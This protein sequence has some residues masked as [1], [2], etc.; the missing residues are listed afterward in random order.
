MIKAVTRPATP[1]V[2]IALRK[3]FLNRQTSASVSCLMPDAPFSP[4]ARYRLKRAQ[5]TKN[6]GKKNAETEKVAE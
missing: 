6:L 4:A 3:N 1:A 5:T 2:T